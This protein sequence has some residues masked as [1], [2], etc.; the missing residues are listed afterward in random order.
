VR[1]SFSKLITLENPLLVPV[2]IKKE[3]ILIESDVIYVSP[4]NFTIPAKSEFGFEIIFRPL[5]AK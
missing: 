4:N 2:Q 5:L 3:M 1:E